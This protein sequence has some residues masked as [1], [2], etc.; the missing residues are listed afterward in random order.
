MY[1]S[2][3]GSQIAENSIFCPKC[4]TEINS[5]KQPQSPSWEQMNGAG[6]TCPQPQQF[7]RNRATS[8]LIC[9]LAFVPI[10]FWLPLVAE[11]KNSLGKNAANQG[12]WLLIIGVAINVIQSIV[13]SLFHWYGGFIFNIVGGL[14]SGL[15]GLVFGMVNI[16][17]IVCMVIGFIHTYKGEK[18]EVPFLGKVTLIN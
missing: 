12:L 16:A 8:N 3:C 6:N 11:Q 5:A 17:L 7:Y 14:F 18:Y 9:A 10:L 15:L 2:K 13:R 4:G 1:C